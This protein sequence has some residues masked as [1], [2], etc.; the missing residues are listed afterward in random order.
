MVI[1]FVIMIILVMVFNL[2][3]YED[4]NIFHDENCFYELVKFFLLIIIVSFFLI[5]CSCLG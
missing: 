3:N 5:K 4:F 1:N 2:L